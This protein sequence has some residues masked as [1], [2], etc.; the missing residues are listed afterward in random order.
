MALLCLLCRCE[1]WGI[2]WLSEMISDMSLEWY[3]KR[4]SFCYYCL[5]KAICS[6]SSSGL[7]GYK[8]YICNKSF[9]WFYVSL[10]PVVSPVPNRTKVIHLK[11]NYHSVKFYG[12]KKSSSPLNP[13]SKLNCNFFKKP[14][15][16]GN[17][18]F[19]KVVGNMSP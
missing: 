15:G 12:P 10:R 4:G 18:L 13:F 14:R 7:C 19:Q 5:H 8:M 2:R 1:S 3:Q 11:I 16:C 17:L 6:I 9:F